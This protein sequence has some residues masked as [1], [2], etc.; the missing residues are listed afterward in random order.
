MAAFGTW[1]L[2]PIYFKAIAAVD[3]VEVLC[4]RVIWSVVFLATLLVVTRQVAALKLVVRTRAA[5]LALLASTVLIAVNWFVFIW[6]VSHD[7]IVEASLGYF[8]NPLVNVLF[9]FMFLRERQRPLQVA[10]IA[11]A[12]VGVAYLTVQVG[13]LPWV[14]LT[15]ACS[16]GLYG[17]VR[18]VLAVQAVVGLTVETLILLVPALGVVTYLHATGQSAFGRG[19]TTID[20]LLVAA[21][22]V[23]AIPLLWFTAAARRLRL[24]TLGFL[25]YIAPSGQFLLAVLYYGERLDRDRMISFTFIWTALAIYS[26]DTLR[27]T[28]RVGPSSAGAALPVVARPAGK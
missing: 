26:W 5:I 14:S 3:P 2:C 1:G 6:A 22:L 27:K 16:F 4:H 25:Q 15:L 20:L 7:Q 19:D 18:K 21:G 9:G 10:S 12:L 28:R 17:L 11:L 13:R 8:I 23:T 24:S